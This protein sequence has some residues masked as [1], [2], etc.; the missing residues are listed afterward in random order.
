MT[1]TA[2]RPSFRAPFNGPEIHCVEQVLPS[3]W[4][5]SSGSPDATITFGSNVLSWPC[6]F[7]DPQLI[8]DGLSHAEMLWIRNFGGL[9]ST[10]YYP[11]VLFFLQVSV[12]WRYSESIT[13]SVSKD[14]NSGIWR[15]WIH[16]VKW[17]PGIGF[18]LHQFSQADEIAYCRCRLRLGTQSQDNLSPL[19]KPIGISQPKSMVVSNR[20]SS[21]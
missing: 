14:P 21:G 9:R 6:W 15:T 16:P 5:G 11:F 20:T 12:G 18:L 3:G 7:W 8:A 13:C 2:V 10:P 4:S 19:R 17:E 1:L